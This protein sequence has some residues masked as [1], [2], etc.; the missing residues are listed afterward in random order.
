M[1]VLVK[2]VRGK[3]CT[4]RTRQAPLLSPPEGW[5]LSCSQFL[6]PPPCRLYLGV[7]VRVGRLAIGLL[8]A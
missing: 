4:R 7:T 1:G 5:L 3:V 2:Q 8:R 6:T